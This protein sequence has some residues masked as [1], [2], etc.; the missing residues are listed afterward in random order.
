MRWVLVLTKHGHCALAPKQ[1][2]HQNSLQSRGRKES[3]TIEI[4][5]VVRVPDTIPEGKEVLPEEKG[6]ENLQKPLF[7]YG[8]V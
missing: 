2:P 6:V 3:K 8:L 7:V 4:T 1:G 5:S